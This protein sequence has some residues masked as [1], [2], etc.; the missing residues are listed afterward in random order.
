MPMLWIWVRFQGI[1][2]TTGARSAA[3]SAHQS[4]KQR[5]AA[6]FCVVAE[7][8]ELY[9]NVLSQICAAALRCDSKRF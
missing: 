9:S 6:K 7:G 5:V 1:A 3:V 4:E 2:E 8:E